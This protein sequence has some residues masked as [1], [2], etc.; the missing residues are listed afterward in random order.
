MENNF[1]DRLFKELQRQGIKKTEFYSDL[2][3][4]RTTLVH[5]KKGSQPRTDV[6]LKICK[7]LKV[8]PYYLWL[9]EEDGFIKKDILDKAKKYEELQKIAEKY[10]A[11]KRIIES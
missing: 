11:I 7:Y 6:Y 5:W 3:I 10:D 1:L 9:G 2:N 8:S 4:S